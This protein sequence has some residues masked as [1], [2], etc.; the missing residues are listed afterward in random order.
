MGLTENLKFLLTADGAQVMREFD[1]VGKA[2]DRDLGKIETRSK[3]S[4]QSM[5]SMGSKMVLA[6]GLIGTA[7]FKSA[8]AAEEANKVHL[9]L[10]NTISNSAKLTDKS[11]EAFEKQSKA[12]QNM[13]VVDD[14]AV[15]SVQSMLGQFGLAED[16]IT[17]LTPLVVDLSRKMGID[18]D[19]AAKMV[20]K[21]V[22]GSTTALKKA[23][24]TVDEAAFKNDHFTATMD[25]LSSKVG[26]FAQSEGATFSGQMAILKNQAAD[27]SE[28]IGSGV[29]SAVSSLLG[30]LTGAGAG[31]G[32]LDESTQ[33]AIGSAATYA[34]GITI[35]AGGLTFATGKAKALRTE[36]AAT[37]SMVGGYKGAI[38]AASIAVTGI[39]TAWSIWNAEMEKGREMSKG[40]QAD[41]AKKFDTSS[42]EQTED[43]LKRVNEQI[44][45][46]REE[47]SGWNPLDADYRAQMNGLADDLAKTHV[48]QSI[49]LEADKA[50]AGQ[51]G[52]TVD[53]LH[54]RRAAQQAATKATEDA[55]DPEKIL[56]KSVSDSLDAWNDYSKAVDGASGK[57]RDYFGI[58]DMKVT[59]Q[60]DFDQAIREMTTTVKE[61][62]N[63]LN[64]MTNQVNL[65]SEAG[66]KNRDVYMAVGERIRDTA[67]A[68]KD[69][70][71]PEAARKKFEELSGSM[72]NYLLPLLGGNK[73][74]VD[75]L[76]TS[77]GL[78]MKTWDIAVNSTGMD[79]ALSKALE[80][81]KQMVIAN[82]GDV[83]LA[84]R[85]GA[86]Y[87]LEQK[88]K[89]K[90]RAVSG[91]V[92]Q[93]ESYTVGEYRPERF[94]PD[95]PGRI[96]PLTSSTPIVSVQIDGRELLRAMS[97][98]GA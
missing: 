75:N 68:L 92:R 74:A 37:G 59:S 71:G 19:A 33:R 14:E 95:G 67:M 93:G 48:A 58:I 18:M 10:D 46:L 55:A 79:L 97:T 7:L 54:K 22:D 53:Q 63:Q 40:I 35:L 94:V 88:A 96:E 1:K 5:V 43:R 50:L 12:I 24:I 60:G 29:V 89:N 80:L 86:A 83:A 8:E 66:V 52:I 36:M 9:K 30:P 17:S 44:R 72:A 45:Q 47:G 65:T 23:G 31:M 13:T 3:L 32:G 87:A 70:E 84:M 25:A 39:T 51:Q 91:P 69:T 77:L 2:A 42:V 11:R 27:L 98:V 28:G 82:G 4:A 64:W 56:T 15:I 76:M 26:G 16:Q 85:G 20:G 81:A 61:N 6:G 73:T 57:M 34:T 78:T 62:G 49:M 38:A 41:L 90:G 21:S